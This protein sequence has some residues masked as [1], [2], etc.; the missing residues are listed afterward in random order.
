MNFLLIGI[1]LLVAFIDWFAVVRL[2]KPLEYAAKP[3]VM[4]LI[5]AWL[6]T[7]G[8]FRIPLLWF[9]L[10]ILFSMAGDICLMLQREQFIAGLVSFLLAHI[11]Y[12]IGLSYKL[13]A[14]NPASLVLA[15]LVFLTASQIYLRLSAGLKRSANAKLLMPVL[16]YTL[17]ISVMLFSALAT[18]VRLDWNAGSAFLVSFG[19]LLFFISD[20]LLAWNKFVHS[21]RYGKLLV[22]VTYHIGQILLALGAAS[23]FLS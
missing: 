23:H 1:A 9:T 2:N 3:G 18:L 21:L 19:A 17:V 8:G 12:I 16:V 15:V 10:G 11:F 7:I 22:I 14:F 13:P 20:S 4:V 6:V 5:L